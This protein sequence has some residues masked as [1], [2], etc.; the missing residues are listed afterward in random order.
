MLQTQVNIARVHSTTK[1]HHLSFML[2]QIFRFIDL[3]LYWP[4][5]RKEIKLVFQVASLTCILRCFRFLWEYFNRKCF[6]HG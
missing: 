5:A 6:I 4:W 1:F 3:T 2:E